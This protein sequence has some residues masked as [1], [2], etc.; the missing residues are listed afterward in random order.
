[1]TEDDHVRLSL[2]EPLSVAGPELV[3]LGEDVAE[4]DETSRPRP[5]RSLDR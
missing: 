3:E 2:G 4:E 5:A 1:V